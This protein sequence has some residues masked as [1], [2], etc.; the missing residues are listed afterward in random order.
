MLPRPRWRMAVLALALAV[1]AASLPALVGSWVYDDRLMLGHPMLDGLEDVGPA[2]SRSSD[3]YQARGRSGAFIAQGTT[4]RPLPMISFILVNGTLGTHPLPHHLVSLL[5][6]LGTVALL[7]RLARPAW[8]A[9]LGVALFALHPAG[10]EAY[11][12]INGRADAMA[13]TLLAGVLV[14]L[15]TGS[16]RRLLLLGLLLFLGALTKETFVV[17]AAAAVAANAAAAK[18]WRRLAVDGVALVAGFGAALALRALAGSAA[19]STLPTVAWG[20]VLERAPRLVALAVETLIVPVPRPMRLLGW[21]LAQPFTWQAALAAALPLLLLAY[22]LL[23]RNFAAA[24][25]VGGALA[26][27]APTTLVGDSFWLGLD[28]YLYLPMILGCAAALPWLSTRRWPAWCVAPAALLAVATFFTARGYA[29][30]EAFAQALHE[31]RP[32]DPSTHLVAAHD[33]LERGDAARARAL[34]LELPDPTRVPSV[35]HEAA[36]LLLVLGEQRVAA[37]LVEKAAAAHPDSQNLRFDLFVLR[38]S[39][40][41]WDDAAALAA[42][43]ADDPAR[44]RALKDVIDGWLAAGAVPPEARA[45]LSRALEGIR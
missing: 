30:H 22:S 4:Y 3:D 14:V 12:W 2:F 39:Q 9:L 10:A 31:A 5:L 29:S 37:V 38:G 45:A 41:R 17:A 36:R 28:R 27:L 1:T 7:C 15:A 18:S 21:E 26:A 24:L 34:L 32:D 19:V 23:R 20:A 40:R 33:A 35:A 13:G 8:A 11:Q 25:L 44:R 6:H 43:L 16:R 42:G